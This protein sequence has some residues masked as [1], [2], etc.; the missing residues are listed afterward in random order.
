MA[1]PAP[2]SGVQHRLGS[3]QNPR[4]V[5]QGG[6]SAV[7]PGTGPVSGGAP[8]RTAPAGRAGGVGSEVVA[9]TG[10]TG[11]QLLL[12]P[13][14]GGVVGPSRSAGLESAAEAI[15]GVRGGYCGG[16][17]GGLDRKPASGAGGGA[18]ASGSEQLAGQNPAAR[19][20]GRQGPEAGRPAGQEAAAGGKGRA[21]AGGIMGEFSVGLPGSGGATAAPAPDWVWERCVCPVTQVRDKNFPAIYW[22]FP[23]VNPYYGALALSSSSDAS[24]GTCRRSSKGSGADRVQKYVCGFFAPK[25]S[26]RCCQTPLFCVYC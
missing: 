10:P 16:G 4:G 18:E 26:S 5:I 11:P 24:H 15:E 17:S 21:P 1:A 22:N 2:A 19:V 14:A 3:D 12:V 6:V 9:R 7:D 20:A 13:E 25:N 8:C 23:A